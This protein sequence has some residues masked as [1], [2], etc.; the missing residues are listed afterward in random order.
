MTRLQPSWH[1]L[2]RIIIT[3]LVLLQTVN[4]ITPTAVIDLYSNQEKI[5]S[6]YTSTAA[7]GVTLPFG[8]P[9]VPSAPLVLAPENN[10]YLCQ[11]V[12]TNT[13]KFRRPLIQR[14]G[15]VE[16]WVMPQWSDHQCRNFFCGFPK[17][18]IS[19]P[20]FLDLLQQFNQYFNALVRY[21][22]LLLSHT[23][24]LSYFLFLSFSLQQLFNQSSNALLRY[25]LLFPSLTHN[26][27]IS[28]SFSLSS[29]SG[30]TH[31]QTHSLSLSSQLSCSGSTSLSSLSLFLSFSVL[32]RLICFS[33][34]I[35]GAISFPISNILSF[36][37][38]FFFSVLARIFLFSFSPSLS[39]FLPFSALTRFLYFFSH[40]LVRYLCLFLSISFIS[41]TPGQTIHSQERSN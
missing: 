7:F 14:V 36:P 29:S 11:P 9:N 32:S 24:S 41:K 25:L 34:S 1:H 40:V 10:P 28:L 30:H 37:L 6:I 21:L 33:L 20:L 31:A 8:K 3:L 2:R 27:T 15:V 19:L 39:F 13:K 4:A 23:H 17:T 35:S 5:E 16:E 22:S 26:L 18:Y 12:E 38:F